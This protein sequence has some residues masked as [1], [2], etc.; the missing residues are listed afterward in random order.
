MRVAIVGLGPSA[1]DFFR[2]AEGLGNWQTKYDEVWTINGFANV[3]QCTRGFAMD[4]VRVQERR[5]AGGNKKIARMLE[6]F[7]KAQ[8]PI[9]T[10]RTHPDYPAL[11]EFPLEAVL[12][13]GPGVRDYFNST[14]AYAIALAVHE[15]A[16]SIDIFGADY[17][18]PDRHIAEKGRGCCEYWLGVASARGIKIGI[19]PTSSMMDSDCKETLYGYDTVK[20]KRG[21]TED[22][23]CKI[24]FEALPEDKWPTAAQIEKRYDKAIKN[25]ENKHA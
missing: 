18:F 24:E 14:I 16:E 9:Y 25:V 22:G 10:S 21:F 19:P 17:T 5:A 15:R 7:K 13:S 11:I 1:T 12:N 2:L 6:A 4:D 8:V 20:V 3:L 23:W